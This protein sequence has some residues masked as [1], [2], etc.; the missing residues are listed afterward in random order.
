MTSRICLRPFAI[1]FLACMVFSTTGCGDQ[2]QRH[3]ST[4]NMKIL[5]LSLHEYKDEHGTWPEELADVESILGAEE[6]AAR[7]QNPLTG[8][9]PGY[10]YVKPPED[11]MTSQTIVLYQLRDGKRDDSLLVGYLDASVHAASDAQ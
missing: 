4:Q 1:V 11:A 9:N 10:E 5:G 3:D 8:D 2:Q 7:I 6:Y